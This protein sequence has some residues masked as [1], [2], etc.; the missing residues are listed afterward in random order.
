MGVAPLETDIFIASAILRR[1]GEVLLVREQSGSRPYGT[2]DLP[3]GQAQT[4]ELS[5]ETLVRAVRE[6][7][8]L[9]VLRVRDLVAVSQRHTPGPGAD[10]PGGDA[11]RVTVFLFE[12][13]EWSGELP[14][15]PPG[16]ESEVRFWKPAEAIDQLRRHPVQA[17]SQPAIAHLSDEHD[18]RAWL[19]R[20]EPEAPETLVWPPASDA[21]EVSETVRQARAIVAL[22]CIVI[23]ALF[24]IIVIIGVITIARP[25]S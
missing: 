11:A 21:L 9:E 5:I 2:W 22:G 16:G 25:F 24:V 18:G 1:N 17:L 19:Y 6:S 14:A 7:T 13:A 4:G 23:L 10:V 15:W 8:G 3:G 12:V 20:Q